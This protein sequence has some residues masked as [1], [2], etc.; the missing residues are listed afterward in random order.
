VHFSD[1]PV[2]GARQI[3]LAGAPG[4]GRQAQGSVRQAPVQQPPRRSTPNVQRSAT[5]AAQIYQAV[6]ISSPADQQTLQNIGGVLD[7]VVSSQP[8]LEPGHRY[9]VVY[10]GQRRN[11]NTTTSRM[12]LSDVFRGAHTLEIVIVDEAG[13]ELARSASITFY[14]QQASVLNRN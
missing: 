11:L 3:E 10:D 14:V 4:L 1:T 5:P 9:D 7:V 6:Q 2:P 13:T 12:T 8:G